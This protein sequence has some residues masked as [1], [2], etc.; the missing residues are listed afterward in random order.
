MGVSAGEGADG[1][2]RERPDWA[3]GQDVAPVAAAQPAKVT[4]G[5]RGGA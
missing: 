1:E 4:P 3:R 2:A 5:G